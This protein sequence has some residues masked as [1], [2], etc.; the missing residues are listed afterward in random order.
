MKHTRIHECLPLFYFMLQKAATALSVLAGVSVL[1]FLLSV[2]SPGD[3][4]YLA[5]KADGNIEPTPVEIREMR[6]ELGLDRPLYLQYARWAGRVIQGDLGTSFVTGEAVGREIARRLP[7]TL[8]LAST[9]LLIAALVG[10]GLG[11]LGASAPNRLRDRL[12]QLTG[13]ALISVPDYWMAILLIGIFSET[14][15]WLPTSGASSPASYILPALVL[16]AGTCGN[17]FRLCRTLLLTEKGKAYI[18]TARSKGISETRILLRHAFFNILIPLVTGL[19]MGFGHMLSG[20]VIVES[21]FSIPGL[22]QFA[23]N[24]VGNR[25]YPVI[26]AYVLYTAA[27]FILVNLLLDL[28]YPLVNPQLEGDRG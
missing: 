24:G 17:L 10:L 9:A 2:F 7:C 12:S 18:F 22:G 8:T 14:L 27:L 3:P 13:V 5:L 23:L 4:A 15:G 21:I 11:L 20:A 26:Q 6:A 19:G 25:D 1:T 16:A 28:L